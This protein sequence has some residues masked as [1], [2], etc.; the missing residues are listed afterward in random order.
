MYNKS[1][2]L[3]FKGANQIPEQEVEG[4]IKAGHTCS[5]Y[6]HMYSFM[7][8]VTFAKLLFSLSFCLCTPPT[9]LHSLTLHLSHRLNLTPPFCGSAFHPPPLPLPPLCP[10]FL[11][12]LYPNLED[13]GD[14]MGLALNSDE[15]Q[16]NLAL[17]PVADNVSVSVSWG[18]VSV[19]ANN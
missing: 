13:L 9:S 4:G 18:C 10:S 6:Y 8:Y 19:H 5:M 2:V 3:R 1:S 7:H 11:L 14:Y 16:R 12:A 15:V 17:L